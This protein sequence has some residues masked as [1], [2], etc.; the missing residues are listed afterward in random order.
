[1]IKDLNIKPGIFHLTEKKVGNS[2]EHMNIGENILNR[3]P[4]AQVVKSRMNK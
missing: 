1:M 4:M 2:V 3:T